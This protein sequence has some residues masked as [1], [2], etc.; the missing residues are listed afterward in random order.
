MPPPTKPTPLTTDQ[1]DHLRNEVDAGRPPAVW[2]TPAAVGV[3]A[4]RSAKVVAFTD[5]TEGDF[6]QVRPTGSADVLSFAPSELT[7]DRPPRRRKGAVEP[8]PRARA[9]S[10]AST[11]SAAPVAGRANPPKASASTPS[12]A[13]KAIDELLVTRERPTRSAQ[14]ARSARTRQPSPVAVTLSSTPDGEWTIDVLT[15]KKR[16]VRAR[17]IAASAV[18]QAAKALGPDVAEAIDGVLAAARERQR[19]RVAELEAELAS[20]RRALSQLAEG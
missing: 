6:I 2:F 14:P 19:G 20:A 13:P 3:D 7:T 17:P 1:I 12:A 11:R 10:A 16:A 5:P 8:A 15:G 4:G 9:G 18:A